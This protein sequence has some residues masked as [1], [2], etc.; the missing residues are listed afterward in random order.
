MAATGRDERMDTGRPS[1]SSNN[2]SNNANNNNTGHHATSAAPLPV[3]SSSSSSSASATS[4]S[5]T[6]LLNK[7]K[8]IENYDFPYCDDSCKYE[9]VAKIGQGTFG[10]VFKAREKKSNKKFVAM[11]KVL[12]DNEKEGVSRNSSEIHNQ[13]S[14][15]QPLITP[16]YSFQLRHCEKFVFCNC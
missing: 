4:K 7:Q 11:K 3:A 1:T 9:K 14:T 12:M 8:Y 5:A 13:F 6:S 10:E 16:F 15:N 2:S